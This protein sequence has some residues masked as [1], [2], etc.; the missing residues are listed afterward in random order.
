M[1]AQAHI[2]HFSNYAPRQHLNTCFE[3]VGWRTLV[4][5]CCIPLQHILYFK[6]NL[7]CKNCTYWLMTRGLFL[8]HDLSHSSLEP[9]FFPPSFSF[10]H[11]ITAC[12]SGYF[13]TYNTTC[14]PLVL[15]PTER[16]LNQHNGLTEAVVA[17]TTWGCLSVCKICIYPHFAHQISLWALSHRRQQLKLIY[18]FRAIK[19]IYLIHGENIIYHSVF[20]HRCQSDLLIRWSTEALRNQI[21][22]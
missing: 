11:S 5:L 21:Y 14:A 17:C 13:S 3:L 8:Y 2:N 22:F 15:P 16:N 12:A 19:Q 6:S 9:W 10:R 7:K 18:M 4:H 1:Q 20:G